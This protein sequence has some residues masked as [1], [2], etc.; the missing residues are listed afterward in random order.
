[1]KIWTELKRRQVI[2]AGVAYLIITWVLAQVADLLLENFAAPDY[3]MQW[4]LILLAVGFPL[5]LIVAWFY[6]ITLAGLLVEEE[7]LRGDTSTSRSIAGIEHQGPA[8]AVLPFKNFSG[9]EDQELFAQAITNDITQ[10]LTQSS[11]LTVVSMSS[12]PDSD[13][14]IELGRTLGVQFLLNGS[15][16]KIGDQLR[17]TAQLT[18]VTNGVDIWS[19]RYDR[20]MNAQSIFEVQDEISDQLVATLSDYHGVVFSTETGRG[21]NR[22]TDSLNAYQL[23]AVALAYD[24]FISEPNHLRAR[25]SL[26]QAVK[27][28]PE[29]AS[30]WGHL[31]WIY[32][33]EYVYSYNQLPDSMVR[34][35]EVAHK[36]VHLAPNDYHVRWLLSRVYYFKGER[37][38]FFVEAEKSLNLNDGDGT[39]IGLIG[40]YMGL[41]DEPERGAQLIEKAK[42]LNP[43]YPDYL[44]WFGSVPLFAK[45]E[46]Q[47]VYEN[48]MQ[49]NL[50]EWHLYNVLLAA[51]SDRLGH[52]ALK[53]QCISNL[54]MLLGEHYLETTHELLKRFL[55][56]MPETVEEIF[57]TIKTK[58]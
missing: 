57:A 40:C 31:S 46:Y 37:E 47:S 58:V 21:I 55:V 48:L 34:A 1:M 3:V 22:P 42:L 41:A 50:G 9:E 53:D 52:S 16:N 29:Y 20:Q 49:A 27:L 36:A 28:D 8:M 13:D 51:T 39:T 18:D 45:G 33:D 25:D 17:V 35:L 54:Q 44:H 12:N 6:K 26:E 32:A 2:Q 23:L 4:F 24:K 56:F 43:N 15:V 30:A 14:P 19:Q 10:G 5:C 38:L 7:L 11:S